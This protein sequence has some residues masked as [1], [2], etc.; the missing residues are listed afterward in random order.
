[1]KRAVVSLVLLSSVSAAFSNVYITEWMYNSLTSGAPE[2]VEITNM[3]AVAVDFTNWSFDDSSRTPDEFSLA[4]IGILA[5]GA[6]A[7]ITEETTAAGF[8]VRWGLAGT[9]QIASGNTDNLGR[10]DEIN[11]YDAADVLV[12]RL[13][14][15]DQTLGGLRTQGISGNP[16]P[17]GG[18]GNPALLGANLAPQWTASVNGDLYGSHFSADNDLGNPGFFAL[19]PVPEPATMAVLGIGALALVRRRRIV[20]GK[21]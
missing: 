12:D 9:I 2:Y 19:Q 3:G 4:E 17:L 8:R 15:D 1:M 6:S 5:P 16:G 14:Y 11:I 21:S 20:R 7:I 18:L 10:A 13:T